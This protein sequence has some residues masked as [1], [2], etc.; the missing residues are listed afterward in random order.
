MSKSLDEIRNFPLREGTSQDKRLV[1]ALDTDHVKVDERSIADFL[2]FAQKYAHHLTFYNAENKADGSWEEFLKNDV[3]Y[4][5]SLIAVENIDAYDRIFQE[6]LSASH[7][8]DNFK[9]R[10]DFLY[11]LALR[12]DQ[13]YRQA[14]RLEDMKEQMGGV[15]QSFNLQTAW[16]L[17]N[18]YYEAAE[19]EGLLTIPGNAATFG[20]ITL[21]L[22]QGVRAE[23]FNDIWAIEGS[24]I[25]D[26]SFIFGDA[27][28]D[29]DKIDRATEYLEQLAEQLLG[30][31]S[32]TIETAN[33]YLTT[34]L[35][36]YPGHEPHVALF[37]AFLRL[38]RLHQDEMNDITSR[39]LDFYFKEVLAIKEKEEEPDNVHVLFE[40]AKFVDNHKLDSGTK[41]KAGKDNE[42]NDVF[43]SLDEEIV[44]NK[45]SVESKKSVFFNKT[46]PNRTIGIFAAQMADSDD[47][48]E[49]PSTEPDGSWT[50]FHDNDNLI[51][52]IGFA[53]GSP[54]LN[55]P[56]GER[57]VTL[58]LG[59]ENAD[60]LE[61]H[62][63]KFL[64]YMTI[65]L[66]TEDEEWITLDNTAHSV[67]A[68][69]I[70]KNLSQS[71]QVK[72]LEI[73]FALSHDDSPVYAVHDSSVLAGL[74]IARIYFRVDRNLSFSSSEVD[75]LRAEFSQF[76]SLISNARVMFYELLVDVRGVKEIN[77]ETALGSIDPSNS[78]FPFGTV[79]SKG[80][81][82]YIGSSQ[83]KDKPI[84]ELTAEIEWDGIPETGAY[85]PSLAFD[86]VSDSATKLT[87]LHALQSEI[88]KKEEFTQL[89]DALVTL[90][91]SKNPSQS[92][93]SAEDSLFN[94]WDLYGQ[95]LEPVWQE[96]K[97]FVEAFISVVGLLNI[98]TNYNALLD[99]EKG[100][101][102]MLFLSHIDPWPTGAR[103][104]KASG[105][106]KVAMDPEKCLKIKYDGPGFG[107]ASYA[108]KFALA[109]VNPDDY[110]FPSEP[111]SPSIKGITLNYKATSKFDIASGEGGTVGD[112]RQ[113]FYHIHPFG[114]AEIVTGNQNA[115]IPLV[116][117]YP[118]EGELYIGVSDLNT[119]QNLSLLIQVAEGTANPLAEST[120]VVWS[121]LEENNW[122]S[123]ETADVTDKTNGFIQSGIVKFQVPKVKTEGNTILPE[124]QFWIRAAIAE[125]TD[126]IC[127]GI[128][129]KAQVVEA[130]YANN[131]NADDFL[132]TPL[133]PDTISKL[134]PNQSQIKTTS[135]PYAS[136]GGRSKEASDHYYIRVSERLRHKNRAVTVWD[137]E[138]LIL[139]NFSD[140]YKV[141]CINHAKAVIN[142]ADQLVSDLIVRP[143][144]VVIILLPDLKNKMSGTA[145]KPFTSLSTLESVEAFVNEC[146]SPFSEVQVINPKFEEI[147]LTIQVC[148]HDGFDEK[149][150]AKQLNEDLKQYLSPWAYE[151]DY[152]LEF[153]GTV[154]KSV[155]LNYVEEREYVDFVTL[156]KLNHIGVHTDT[157]EAIAT[158]PGSILVSAASHSVNESEVEKIE[159][160]QS[161]KS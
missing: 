79:P 55:L 63:S 160:L 139:E 47:G 49:E 129:I 100:I 65:E 112:D 31:F 42:G 128:D 89:K 91:T 127:N 51:P 141:K 77:V 5:L 54:L 135:Q 40:L 16:H 125:N 38:V 28:T 116:P 6:L 86:D 114:N 103:V 22:S 81:V 80:N 111:Y 14:Y 35:E 34:S 99:R 87:R 8:A 157:D 45:A 37:L 118:N 153:G 7:N 151:S 158:T 56:E 150:Y 53:V 24:V 64:D 39:H 110:D 10:F 32:K 62:E 109:T 29:S 148:F 145:L 12:V 136:F 98:L 93:F 48:I 84:T 18:K 2:V 131:N 30:A 4:L 154:Y 26:A 85:P 95:D 117:E 58:T 138:R 66:S 73:S 140:V 115:E 25:A 36:G 142:A 82:F 90:H 161:G 108:Q 43:Y 92:V 67:E 119:P 13:G 152:P 74:P 52:D 96:Q 83:L 156:F 68:R 76:L 130:S 69:I 137:Y 23:D 143:G 59:L 113:A 15:I 144:N 120:K 104:I 57:L 88:G 72:A 122:I 133:S 124:G 78:F 75:V 107:H 102:I 155:I 20:S 159:P 134:S 21:S 146:K 9:L 11:T 1:Q 105:P 61:A 121:Y 71:E 132:E 94:L 19:A 46:N 97:A 60:S 123:F 126:A 44:V 149:F 33:T 27:V 3:S 101:L 41:L 17:L 147:Q 50:I 106:S 70:D